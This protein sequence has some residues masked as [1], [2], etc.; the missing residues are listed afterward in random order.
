MTINEL[1]QTEYNPYFQGYLSLVDE[2]PLL[3]GLK[4]GMIVTQAYFEALPVTKHEHRYAEGK[5]TP[6]EILLH[7]VDTERMF[8][9]RALS[10]AR[11]DNTDLPGFDENEF[12]RNSFANLR[13]MEDIIKEFVTVRL[14]TIDMFRSFSDEVLKRKGTANGS[15]LSVRAAGFLICGHEKHHRNIITERYL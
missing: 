9:Y 10:F 3:R 14:A 2:V 6:K 5:W 11:N 13:S 4:A 15:T 7:L 12:A 1:S 8:C